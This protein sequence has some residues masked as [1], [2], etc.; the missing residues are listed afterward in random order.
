MTSKRKSIKTA[1]ST[2]TGTG[3]F[4][5]VLVTGASRGIGADTAR[6]FARRGHPVVVTARDT[7][8]LKDVAASIQSSG[9]TAHVMP[10]DLAGT[11]KA[12]RFVDKLLRA[13]PDLCC[14]V[15]NAGLAVHGPVVDRDPASFMDEFDVNYFAPV[16][17]ARFVAAHWQ[18]QSSQAAA[19]RRNSIIAVSS[20]T[21]TV[22]F[23]G[24][25]NYGASKAALN[26]LLRN[27]RVEL[28]SSGSGQGIH[29]GIVLPG[30]TETAM[31]AELESLLPGSSPVFI[32]E[33]VW[34]CF[35]RRLD[36]VVP[37]L[38]NKVAA[39][40]FRFFPSVSDKILKAGAGFLVPRPGKKSQA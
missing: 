39:G 11:A 21:A 14:V 25:A 10:A 37:G 35:E 22:P 20:L 7:E 33:S 23:P 6:A 32:A 18:G 28:A 12:K 15:L 17:I 26:Q 1:F 3:A 24:H 9:G 8:E 5:P 30:Y 13:H 38:D 31:T 4:R 16:T 29:V 40:L 34:D 2:G 36:E 27:L 19:A